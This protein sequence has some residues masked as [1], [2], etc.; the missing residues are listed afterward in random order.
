MNYKILRILPEFET[1]TYL[2]WDEKTSEAI[3]IDPAF[4]APALINELKNL[5]LKYV[6]NTHGHGDHIGGNE[7]VLQNFKVPLCIHK[8]D[9]EMLSNPY[10]N[11]S[12]SFGI[13]IISPKADILL[14]DGDKIIIG[15]EVIKVIHTPGH[16]SGGICLHTDNLLFSGDTLFCESIGRTDLPSGDFEQLKK[17]ILEK[18]FILPDETIVLPGHGDSTTIGKEK[19]ENPF[20]GIIAKL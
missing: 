8:N 11:L 2:V 5:K 1:N 14:K 16:T 9:A 20:V 7:F 3:I 15:N 13:D 17:S 12:N 4:P 18:L 6:V 10:L 19:I